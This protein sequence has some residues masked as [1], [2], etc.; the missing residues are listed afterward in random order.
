MKKST[1]MLVSG[2]ALGL[3]AGMLIA[4]EKGSRSRKKWSKK[5]KR[6]QKAFEEKL[7]EYRK[8]AAAAEERAAGA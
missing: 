2:I 5:G 1:L 6:Y 4:G 7:A 3:V 8:R